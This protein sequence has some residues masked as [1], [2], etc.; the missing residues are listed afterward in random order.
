[1]KLDI[2]SYDNAIDTLVK[3]K[4]RPYW[5]STS[6]KAFFRSIKNKGFTKQKNKDWYKSMIN[7]LQLSSRE[8]VKATRRILKE[9]EMQQ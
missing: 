5:D 2:S 9:R 8:R 1:M 4:L 3:L 7:A 6:G